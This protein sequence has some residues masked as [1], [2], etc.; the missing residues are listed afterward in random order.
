MQFHLIRVIF[1]FTASSGPC[2]APTSSTYSSPSGRFSISPRSSSERIRSTIGNVESK[3]FRSNNNKC[4]PASYKDGDKGQN[5]T[6]INKEP[7]QALPEKHSDTN[8]SRLKETDTKKKTGKN[9]TMSLKVVTRGTSPTQPS[10]SFVRSRRQDMCNVVEKQVPIV[11]K[12]IETKDEEVQVDQNEDSRFSRLSASSK[13]SGAPW[14]SYLDKLNSSSSPTGS[15]YSSRNYTT[16]GVSTASRL[17]NY[18][19]FRSNE[20]PSSSRS[21]FSAKTS[22]GSSRDHD[23]SNNSNHNP[24]SKLQKTNETSKSSNSFPRK[25]SETKEDKS[26]FEVTPEREKLSSKS[27]GSNQRALSIERLSPGSSKEGNTTSTK[28]DTSS[29]KSYVQCER[30]GSISKSDNSLPVTPQRS[31]STSSKSKSIS[32]N[33]RQ[34]TRSDSST[35]SAVNVP[36]GKSKSSSASSM[37]NHSAK[38]KAVPPSPPLPRKNSSSST[39]SVSSRQAS[40]VD[41]RGK[42]PVPKNEVGMKNTAAGMR[43]INKDFRKSVLNMENGDPTRSQIER[44]RKK[45]RRSMSVSSQD[46]QSEPNSDIVQQANSSGS[47]TSLKSNRSNSRINALSRSGS[48]K[49]NSKDSVAQADSHNFQNTSISLTFKKHSNSEESCKSSS[50]DLDSSEEGIDRCPQ[51][52][53]SGRRRRASGSPFPEG[54]DHMSA[55]SSRTSILASS[56]DEVSLTMEKPSRLPSRSRSKQDKNGKTEEAKF[57]LMKALAPVTS[58]FKAKPHES[59][60]IKS[61]GWINSNEE[62]SDSAKKA[63]DNLL[64]KPM[65]HS[66]SKSSSFGNSDKNAEIRSSNS[67]IRHQSS[68]EKPWWLDPNSDNVPEGV[69]RNS[70]GNDDISQETTVS[71]VLPDDGIVNFLS[72]A[73]NLYVKYIYIYIIKIYNKNIFS[74]CR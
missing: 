36:T 34:M 69:E 58:L 1:I 30:K 74:F 24:Q 37:T 31:D 48:R 40:S 61:D 15:S 64:S 7:H 59:G 33:R 65:P 46:S 44:S 11:S 18:G 8:Q 57:F 73:C 71:T 25:D 43:Y 32:C 6:E 13:I 12:P 67:R 66:T 14:A 51:R 9:G 16:S 22:S 49:H 4:L 45:N 50:S 23:I 35:G 42:P 26:T 17:G 2:P 55:G 20:S 53:S 56:T 63:D 47:S 52:S 39:T 41:A 19:Y 54:K 10:S 3:P 28:S 27:E 70:I 72:T 29:I 5:S 62:Y 38:I 68:G 60:E 21:D